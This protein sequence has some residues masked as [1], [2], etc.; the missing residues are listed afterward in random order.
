MVKYLEI[1]LILSFKFPTFFHENFLK[2]VAT[3]MIQSNVPEL[4]SKKTEI[5]I[6]DQFSPPHTIA[7]YMDNIIVSGHWTFPHYGRVSK[8][9]KKINI[10]RIESEGRTQHDESDSKSSIVK[11]ITFHLRIFSH[12][13]L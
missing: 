11:Y 13:Y 1:W 4:L 2:A 9:I 6:L 10:K 12:C 3:R 7:K 8:K 5:G